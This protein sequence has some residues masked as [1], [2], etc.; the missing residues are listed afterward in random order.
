MK[1]DRRR[2]EGSILHLQLAQPVRRGAEPADVGDA[3]VHLAADQG[4]PRSPRMREQVA[5]DR[6]AAGG[7]APALHNSGEQVVEML[8]VAGK[9]NV[10]AD[11]QE[12]LGELLLDVFPPRACV[13][14]RWN[15]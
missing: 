6:K 8:R 9:K 10:V 15:R 2:R 11:E 4:I 5:Q 1:L 3:G 7:V 14:W 13:S 12:V